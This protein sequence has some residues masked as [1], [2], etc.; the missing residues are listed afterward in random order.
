MLI[1]LIPIP[2]VQGECSSASAAYISTNHT[3]DS[4]PLDKGNKCR[5]VLALDILCTCINKSEHG[6][7]FYLASK[8]SKSNSITNQNQSS[9]KY[10]SIQTRVRLSTMC[11]GCLIT[12]PILFVWFNIFEKAMPNDFIVYQYQ[13]VKVLIKNKWYFGTFITRR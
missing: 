6:I 1:L 8:L 3:P 13:S 4:Q 7:L 9:K 12:F 11:N 2:Y 10:I 5:L